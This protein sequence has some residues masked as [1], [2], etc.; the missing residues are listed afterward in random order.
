MGIL[1]KNFLW[2]VGRLPLESPHQIPGQSWK[3]TL[4]SPGLSSLQLLMSVMKQGPTVCCGGK[5]SPDCKVPC[6]REAC[7]K[8]FGHTLWGV[9]CVMTTLMCSEGGRVLPAVFAGP[10]VGPEPRQGQARLQPLPLTKVT[11]FPDS[12]AEKSAGSFLPLSFCSGP[13]L[14]VE[15]IWHQGRNLS[16]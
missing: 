10:G 9:G 1:Q 6:Q 2:K 8:Y 3:L 12:T 14:E 11:H 7:Y 16:G 13:P 5:H 4:T 15:D